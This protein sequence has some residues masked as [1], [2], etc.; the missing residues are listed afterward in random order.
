MSY[1]TF[2]LPIPCSQHHCARFLSFSFSTMLTPLNP[3]MLFCL[4]K[5]FGGGVDVEFERRLDSA[6]VIE[7]DVMLRVARGGG[8]GLTL[9]TSTP[10]PRK[11]LR[12]CHH[13]YASHRFLTKRFLT[14]RTTPNHELRILQLVTARRSF[15]FE[16]FR[17]DLVMTKHVLMC[18]I[19]RN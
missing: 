6:H 19:R 5:R 14:K 18:L 10:V 4:Q 9:G 7:F 2:S 12:S 16:R 13:L 3:Q 8:T 11:K 17:T 15:H 1:V